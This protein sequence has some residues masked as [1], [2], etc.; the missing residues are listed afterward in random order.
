MKVVGASSDDINSDEQPYFFNMKGFQKHLHCALLRVG[1]LAR[2]RRLR[3][4]VFNT[5]MLSA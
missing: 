3:V 2:L 5:A 4:G 1:C